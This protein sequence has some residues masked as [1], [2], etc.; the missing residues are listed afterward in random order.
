MHFRSHCITCIP[1]ACGFTASV[2]SQGVL[3]PLARP[4]SWNL[5][6]RH[7]ANTT[8]VVRVR[9][10]SLYTSQAFHTFSDTGFCLL[11]V[12]TVQSANPGYGKEKT[13]YPI[14]FVLFE[15]SSGDNII[16]SY[17]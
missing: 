8:A 14:F 1:D 17:I 16:L 10:S 2:L 6:N 7:S 15:P 9:M 3:G 11:D 5:L 12:K 4:S 13:F